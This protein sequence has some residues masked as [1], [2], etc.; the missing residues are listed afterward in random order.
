METKTYET[1]YTLFEGVEGEIADLTT[2]IREMAQNKR[3]F[4]IAKTPECNKCK[5]PCFK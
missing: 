1:D 2:Y 3:P 4:Q 5:N